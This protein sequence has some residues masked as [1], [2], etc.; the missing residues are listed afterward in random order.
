MLRALQWWLANNRYYRNIQINPNALAMLPEDGDLT[1]L[2]SVTLNSTTK[3]P[4]LPSVQEQDP[5][6]TFISAS[7][8]P[9]TAQRMTEQE[10]VRQSVQKRQSH[11]QPV[12]PPALSWPH[13]GSTPINEFNT[14]AYISCAFPTLSPTGAA[15]FVAPRP[16]N[17]RELFQ[18]PNDVRRWT[19]CQ[20]FLLSLLALNMEMRWRV[21]QAGCIYIR[22]HPHDAQLSVKE[23]RDMVGCEGEVFSNR[24]LHYATSLR[25]TR[26][27]WFKQR[28]QLI[29]MVDMLGL[30]TIFFTH[31]A[32]DLH[33]P[34]LTRLI[35]PDDPD[36]TSSHSKAL[37]EN[38][39]IA[40]WFFHQRIQKFIDGFY[41]S[42]LGATDFWL[43]ML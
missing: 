3:D 18:T 17:Y 14:E 26:Q 15:D 6:N 39:A 33:W 2:H 9:S 22:Q 31:S 29:A 23:L 13:S 40:N 27:Y 10:T 21:L 11:L 35:Y 24:F 36:S 5:Y 30:P 20:T 19:I 4:E 25:G 32:A 37:Q 43:C 1:G 38:P 12:V 41:V 42:V 28:S 8:V 34:E 7:F 16:L